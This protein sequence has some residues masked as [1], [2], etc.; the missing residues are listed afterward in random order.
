MEIRRPTPD[1]IASDARLA[2]IDGGDPDK[3]NGPFVPVSRRQ[4]A[5]LSTDAI[6]TVGDQPYAMAKIA[7]ASG[8]LPRT[9]VRIRITTEIQSEGIIAL[10]TT[11]TLK[12][13]QG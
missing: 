5:L 11:L 4:A 7:A 2:K 10:P 3:L 12:P 6:H 13:A 1:E 8:I 9:R